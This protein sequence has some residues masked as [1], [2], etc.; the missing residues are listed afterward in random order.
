VIKSWRIELNQF[1]LLLIIGGFGGWSFDM[2]GWGIALVLIFYTGWHLMRLRELAYWMASAGSRD[3]PESVGL[4]GDI[5]EY[6]YRRERTHTERITRLKRVIDRSRQ[7]VNAISDGLVLIDAHDGMSW[8]NDAAGELLGLRKAT[9]HGQPVTNLLRDPRFVRYFRQANFETHVDIPSPHVPGV[10]LQMQIA[11]YGDNERLL[12]ARDITH[13]HNLEQVRKDFVANV[14]HELR[15]PLTVIKGYLETFL[16]ML[17]PETNRQLYRGLTQMSQQTHRMEMLVNDLLL[18]SRL[19]NEHNK[20]TLRPVNVSGMLRQ[21]QQEAHVLNEDKRHSIQV[22]ADG[23]L[24][25]M[26][27]ESQ[28]RSAFSN[29]LVNAIKY[30]PAGGRIVVLWCLEEKGARLEVQDTGEGIDPIHIPRLTERFYRADQSRHK[31]TGGTGL[32]LAIVKHVLLHHGGE[33]EIQS[34]LGKGSSFICHFPADHVMA[35]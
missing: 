4:W 34:T 14:S 5:F 23:D 24:L 3:V 32:G 20:I 1:L 31:Q 25:L 11:V 22:Q 13:V 12:V 16:N 28:L 33:L 6:L 29:L 30:T 17:S 15:T 18:L 9:D 35:S 7:S 2:A 10:F 27:D 8:W 26:G 19:E 21:I